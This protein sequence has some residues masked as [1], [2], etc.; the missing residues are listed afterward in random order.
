MSHSQ[1]SD[2]DRF[3]ELREKAN[4]VPA[5][6]VNESL[7][8]SII[9]EGD[10]SYIDWESKLDLMMKEQH[11]KTGKCDLAVAKEPI[12]VDRTALAFQKGF[13]WI[14]HFNRV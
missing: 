11:L 6:G 4:F 3:K 8:A 7:F 12:F 13:P 10:H 2:E 5:R 1:I 9:E 14:P